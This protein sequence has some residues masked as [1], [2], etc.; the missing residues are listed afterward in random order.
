MQLKQHSLNQ[1]VLMVEIKVN[2]SLN[3]QALLYSQIKLHQ[4]RVVVLKLTTYSFKVIQQ[5]QEN[6]QLELQHQQMP[7]HPV[8]SFTMR[9]P[10][11]VNMLVGF[12]QMIRI[13]E[14]LALS[15]LRRI[16]ISTYLIR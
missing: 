8:I 1:F 6:I 5:L 12:T 2:Q 7:E 11:K 3:L 15:V 9:H 4:L 16:K 14:D 10:H 13:G